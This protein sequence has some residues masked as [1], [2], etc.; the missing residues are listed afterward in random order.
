MT[1]H[2]D[3]DKGWVTA[4]TD[5]APRW[6]ATC[7]A[8]DRIAGQEISWLNHKRR[9]WVAH[10]AAG[11]PIATLRRHAAYRRWSVTMEGFEFWGH[12]RMLQKDHF[13]AVEGFD[14]VDTAKR[15]VKAI[16]KEA[17]AAL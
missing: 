12:N 8:V 9:A 14:N 7:A 1:L 5:G 10:L 15:F 17:G 6:R 2:W 4:D 11:T 16:L 3:L 13:K